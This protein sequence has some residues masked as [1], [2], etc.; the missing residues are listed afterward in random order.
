MS[1]LLFWTQLDRLSLSGLLAKLQLEN[2]AGHV[3]L[4]ES[5]AGGGCPFGMET[6]AKWGGGAAPSPFGPNRGQTPDI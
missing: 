4:A 1:T 5:S 2:F 6:S 3:P